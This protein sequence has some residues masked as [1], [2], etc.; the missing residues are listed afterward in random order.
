M[1]LSKLA[2]GIAQRPG[3]RAVFRRLAGAQDA[4]ELLRNEEAE[5]TRAASSHRGS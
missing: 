3:S 2:V 1:G 5:S 4:D